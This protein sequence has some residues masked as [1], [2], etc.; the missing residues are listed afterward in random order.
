MP[1][2]RVACLAT[3]LLAL[4]T[5]SGVSATGSEGIPGPTGTLVP[6][7]TGHPNHMLVDPTTV[8]EASPA[9]GLDA[10]AGTWVS[11]IWLPVEEGL[12]FPVVDLVTFDGNT[13]RQDVLRWF[14]DGA[15]SGPPA[16]RV[17][18]ASA[19]VSIVSGG[20]EIGN[21]AHVGPEAAINPYRRT[22]GGD[23]EAF[24]GRFVAFMVIDVGRLTGTAV[25]DDR[26]LLTDSLGKTRSYRRV[27]KDAVAAGHAFFLAAELSAALG[28]PCMI[29]A[30]RG[31]QGD[32]DLQKTLEAA[33]FR[34]ADIVTAGPER[35][36]EDGLMTTL[37]ASPDFKEAVA[38]FSGDGPPAF[39]K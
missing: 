20:V 24:A 4:S 32:P 33:A 1:V 30:L 10:L 23:A 31:D 21:V 6:K 16:Y 3:V 5:V 15:G 13:V 7:L 11:D 22:V 28:W 19:T 35:A 34:A 8:A 17:P 12:I 29:A 2:R 25:A 36:A 27:P 9:T 26:L 14:D 39:C 18:L 38:L 37:Q